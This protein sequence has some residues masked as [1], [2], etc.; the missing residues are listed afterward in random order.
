[1]LRRLFGW[2]S[3]ERGEAGAKSEEFSAEQQLKVNAIVEERLARERVKTAPMVS[4][5]EDLRKFKADHEKQIEAATQKELEA[6]KEYEK[7]KEGWITKE[8]EYQGLISKKDG[9]IVD[10]KIG[11]ALISEITKQNAY[12]EEAMAL[13]KTQA[14]IDKDGN[15]RIKGKDANGLDTLHSVEE[16]VK[17]FL[18]DR[19]HLV[20][21]TNRTGGGTPPAG[22]AGGGAAGGDDLMTLT[23]KMLQAQKVGDFKSVK[24]LKEKVQSA[25]TSRRT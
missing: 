17:K 2:L 7:L 21:A 10:M 1:M 13:L 5:V 8:K 15:I 14:V 19:P 18:T 20:K 11:N 12:A 16:G 4:E 6:K 25:M 23:N 22:G 9:D 3:S 24:D